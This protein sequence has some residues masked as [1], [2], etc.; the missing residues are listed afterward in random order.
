MEINHL[1]KEIDATTGVRRHRRGTKRIFTTAS[2]SRQRFQAGES[3][4]VRNAAMMRCSFSR[5]RSVGAGTEIATTLSPTARRAMAAAEIPGVCSSRSK[6]IPVRRISAISPRRRSATSWAEPGDRGLGVGVVEG[7]QGRF[8]V[9]GRLQR[10][11]DAD[12]RDRPEAVRRLDLVDEPHSLATQ[13]RQ[14]DRLAVGCTRHP[15]DRRA[16]DGR[17]VRPVGAAE[18]QQ[19]LA[20]RKTALRIDAGQADLDQA[21]QQAASRRL[22][23]TK[24][25]AEVDE[26]Q[27]SRLGGDLVERRGGATQ[28]LDAF[29]ATG[30]QVSFRLWHDST[31]VFRITD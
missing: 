4:A 11:P 7:R 3:A 2:P 8:S 12:G 17:D 31:I 25:L 18:P 15:L 13:Y 22:G 24:P 20:Q 30:R 23:Q 28:H 6:A 21:D 27:P 10:E 16:E 14:V 5:K 29:V 9:G 1:M 19:P 26:A